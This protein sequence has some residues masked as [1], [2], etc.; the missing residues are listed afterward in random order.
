MAFLDWTRWVVALATL[1]VVGLTV[2]LHYAVLLR[3]SRR[4]PTLTVRRPPRVMILIFIVLLAHASEILLFAFAYYA[5][6]RLGYFGSIA[7]ST[8]VSA[9][10]D[11][12]YFSSTVYSTVGFGDVVPVGPIRLLAS[13]EALTGLVMISWSASFT[14][15]Q[16][17]RDWP[18][19]PRPQR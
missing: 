5:L 4:L 9:L 17:Q 16:M 15:L 13:M 19:E 3:C 10:I 8:D 18:H 1:V 6:G 2:M 11:Y 12:A 14:F 7:G